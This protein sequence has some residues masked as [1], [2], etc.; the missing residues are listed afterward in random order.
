MIE[1]MN[2]TIEDIQLEEENAKYE[3]HRR[4]FQ[5]LMNFRFKQQDRR[6]IRHNDLTT[7]LTNG[8]VNTTDHNETE[9]NIV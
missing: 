6:N 9:S 7:S 8:I 4:K 3:T 5:N 1:K 2:E